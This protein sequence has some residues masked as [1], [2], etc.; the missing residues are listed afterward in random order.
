MN[1]EPVLELAAVGKS[2]RDY[3]STWWRMAGWV[4]GSPSHFTDHWVLRDVSLSMR[5]GEAV[6]LVGRNGAGKST[7]LKL[8]AGTLAATEG[9]VV[10]RGRVNAILEL[11]MGF[12]PEFTG[13][14]NAI[15][16]CGLLGHPSARI[17]ELVPWIEAFADIGGYFDQPLRTYSSG[18]AMRVAFAVAT[19]A[20]PDILIVDEV[21]S[22][23]DAAFQRKSLRRIEEFLGQG[24]SLLFV[25]HATESIKALCERALWLDHGRLVE[26]GS[27]KA[28]AEAYE[29]SL[30]STLV[31]Q[32]KEEEVDAASYLD[33]SLASGSIEQQYGN[34][35]ARIGNVRFADQD[36]RA[37]NT[38]RTG[39]SF[40]VEFVVEFKAPCRDTHFGILLKTVEGVAVYGTNT[41]RSRLRSDFD[42]GERVLVAFALRNHLSP[43]LYYLNC[44]AS[45]AG[46]TGRDYLHRRVDVA[47]LKVIPRRDG[48]V[49]AGLVDLDAKPILRALELVHS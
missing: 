3:S 26:D 43:G 32:C 41:D 42:A 4:T 25:T 12:N 8:V 1:G 28:V 22:V 37:V 27:A 24:S 29:R 45:V 48:D 18:M 17:D 14:A 13:R 11:G 6:G 34:G 5:R 16:A 21:L 39:D 47:V 44:G 49:I 36:G 33:E 10:T 20:R 23:G 40:S 7:L 19:A 35:N 9:T 46:E 30:F 38:V 2:Y 31:P 15:H